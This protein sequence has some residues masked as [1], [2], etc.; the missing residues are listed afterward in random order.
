MM[1]VSN[2]ELWNN[3]GLCCFHASQYD[4]IYRCFE[5]A[6]LVADDMTQADVWCALGPQVYPNMFAH[7]LAYAYSMIIAPVW[8]LA[9]G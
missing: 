2:A 6:L 8:Q 3:L 4:M 1:G 9:A 7:F 5:N